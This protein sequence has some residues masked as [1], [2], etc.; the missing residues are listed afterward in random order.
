MV[1][2]VFA[3]EKLLSIRYRLVNKHDIGYYIARDKN[4]EKLLVFSKGIC[5]F[6]KPNI[7]ECIKLHFIPG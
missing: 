5:Y 4:N 1:V 7:P 3:K 6:E 2:Q